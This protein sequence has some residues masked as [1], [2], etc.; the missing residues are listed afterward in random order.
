MGWTETCATDQRMRFVLTVE[1]GVG[2][3]LRMSQWSHVSTGGG[4]SS[5]SMSISRG[6]TFAL[7][8]SLGVPGQSMATGF[9]RGLF[10]IWLLLSAGWIMSWLIDLV[11]SVLEDGFKKSDLLVMPVLLFAPSIALLVFVVVAGWGVTRLQGR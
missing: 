2:Q 9:R 11:L 5:S 8:N 3:R 6:L 1:E 7:L 4:S 10:R